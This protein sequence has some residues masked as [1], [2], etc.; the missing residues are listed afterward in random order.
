MKYE[1]KLKQ[2]N[3]ECKAALVGLALTIVVWL[4]CGFGLSN[5]NIEIFS[6]P[7]WIVAGLGGTFLFACIFS[8]VFAKFI[9]QDIALEEEEN[10]T[11]E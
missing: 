10:L 8:V 7:L 4:V 5:M 6:T 11:A 1:D 3:K 2:C 9:M